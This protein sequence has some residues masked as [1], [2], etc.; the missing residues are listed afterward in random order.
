MIDRMLEFSL[1][2]PGFI[3]L[4]AV[5][6]LAAGLWSA[7][8]LPIDAVPDITAPQ[9]Q[10]NTE[11]AALAAEE[12]E[13]LVTRPIEIALA[14]LP[15][16]DEMRSL[17][18]FGLSQVT[19]QFKD[20]T[21][22]YRARQLV[23][24]RLQGVLEQL[25][26][27]A[28]PKLAPISTGIGEIL[29][30]SVNYRA[31]AKHKPPTELEQLIELSEIQEYVIKPL[32]RTVPGIADIN[33][34]GGYERQ[35][36]VQ[37]KPDALAD[38]G[39]TFSE[40]ADLIA[41]N[42]ENVGGGIISR[43][44]EQ[45]TIRAVS[46]VNNAEDIANLPLKFGAGV[47]P[48]LVKDVAEVKTGTKFRTGAATLDGHET[49][50]GT[51][52]ML[53]GE[54]SRE[55]AD[56][57]KTR[58]AEIQ[59]KL[60]EGVEIQIQ[61]DRS[62]LIDRTV[63]TVKTN[64]FEGAVLVVVVLL[65]LLGNWRAALIV[66][67]AIPLS[68]L[69]A[70]MGM[71]RFGISGNLMSLG[72]VDFGLI[73]DGAVVIVENVV[74]Q[75]GQ[76]QHQL[77]RALTVEERALTVLSASKQV[78]TPMFFGVVIIT[79]VYIPILALTGIEGKMFHPMALTVMLA[80]AGA[81]LLSLTLMPVLCSFVLRGKVQEGDNIV[82]RLAKGGYARI[83]SVALRFRWIVVTTA[84]ALFASSVW[85]FGHLGAEFVPKLDE[86]SITAMLYKPVGM[87]IEESLKTDIEVENRILQA[88]PEVTRVFTR[89]GTSE[90]ATD[91]MPPNESDVYIF[92]KPL[93]DWP[94]TP[95][96]PSNKA[97]LRE[98]IE[99]ML[100]T[101]NPDYSILFAQP[102]EMRFNEMLEGT[103]AEVS[104]KI[105]GNDYDVLEN[106]AE[107]IKGILEQTPGVAQV[108][109]E[110]EG[111]TPQL[112]IQ[113]NRDVLR[114]YGLQAAEANKAISVALAGQEVGVIVD[115]NRRYDIVVRMPE[116]LR[117]DDQQI[118][119]LPVRVGQTGLVPLGKLV[120]FKTLK[121]VEPIRRDEGQRRAALM[122][123]LNVRDVEGVVD[124]AERRIKEQVQLP[125]NY[126]IEFGGQFKNL[127]EARTR[128][129][130]VVPSALALIFVLIFFAFGSL[131]Q[132]LLVYS[133]IPLAVTGGVL[134][135]W[136]R[137]MPFSITAAVGFIALSGVA[138]LNGLV[139]ISYFNQ[140]RE[141]G[142]SIRDAVMEGSLT[143][144]RPV[145]MTALVASLGFVPMAVAMGAGAEVQRPL[146]TVVIGGILSSTFLT[147]VL[148]P[149]LYE[150]VEGRIRQSIPASS[151]AF[152]VEPFDDAQGTLRETSRSPSNSR[153]SSL[154]SE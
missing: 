56:R 149:V 41:Q 13:K 72:A 90:I 124:E 113:V 98:Q 66:A 60:P 52:M 88:F 48:L 96:R 68:F 34:S 5:I 27:G 111:R 97:E 135:L 70:L 30:Y 86:G 87:S 73:I 12:S 35:F 59:T 103:K 115:G 54:N 49:V 102:I 32:L 38:M 105:F 8:Q 109:F 151:P 83:L 91:P 130:V 95:G 118:K 94:Q 28:L 89:I 43:G 154:R 53:A 101:I 61:Y 123:N 107:Q 69:F 140:L 143:R 6:L 131:R 22:I 106:R 119:R 71:T 58:V 122:V 63:H 51:T 11:V 20:G 125:D 153:D 26:V 55:V 85:L 136:L 67:S 50:M 37:P 44:T 33:E 79:V 116:Q 99:A 152:Q 39:M 92:Y 62:Q 75:L 134:A 110:T 145:L 1:R 129:A 133:G 64:L 17:T 100:K 19:I 2:Q 74:R 126:M 127:Q 77:G 82:I 76:R 14:G 45:L 142:K 80:L 144:L 138:M 16:V 4:A 150:W 137:G 104:V 114:R 148:I 10:V 84:V 24:E 78:G 93:A 7:L 141:E 31:D 120:E 57:V 132:A 147:L 29:Y 25:P 81:L 40:L 65:G 121:T 42:V 117:A 15:G 146:A 112:Q 46:R 23:A 21:D 36:V 47:T 128:L 3:L 9:V 108:E 139:M 18:K